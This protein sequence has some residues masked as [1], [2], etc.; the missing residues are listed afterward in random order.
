MYC[1][2]C[3]K[4]VPDAT[5]FCPYCGAEL[6]EFVI[7]APVEQASEGDAPTEP[8]TEPLVEPL[9]GGS[10]SDPVQQPSGGPQPYGWQQPSSGQQPF[11]AP[12][13]LSG[14]QPLSNQGPL[15][16]Q[17]PSYGAQQPYG[18]QQPYGAQ[19]PYGLQ[20][21]YGGQQPYGAQQPYGQAPLAVAPVAEPR[22]KGSKVP[23]IIVGIVV[24]LL[25]AG[26]VTAVATGVFT[27]LFNKKSAVVAL[28]DGTEN[29]LYGTS[30]GTMDINVGTSM[31]VKWQFG[32]DLAS[33]TIWGYS[34]GTGFVY[35]NDTLYYY[36][37]SGSGSG[38][39]VSITDE[40][41]GVIADLND[42]LMSAYGVDV[43]F[44]KIVKNGK[45]DRTYIES[46]NQE[47]SDASPS[48]SSGYNP[49]DGMDTSKITEI[50]NDFL[51]NEVNKQAVQDKFMSG[52][53][54]SSSGGTTTYQG[55]IDPI[56]F[57]GAL[58]D[59]ASER[60]KDSGYSS[61]ASTIMDLCDSTGY[62]SD[63]LN[64]ITVKISVKKNMLTGL[65]VTMGTSS[66]AISMS[67]DVT[68]INATDLSNDAT[69]QNILSAPVSSGSGSGGSGSSGSGS[70]LLD[71]LNGLTDA[72]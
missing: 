11:G 10:Q 52:V 26:G 40:S 58:R 24:I 35:T 44:N 43:D 28:Y 48:L 61:A 59:Y 12:Q 70:S 17:Q 2:N 3:G 19:P 32:K 8:P 37:S 51:S 57:F 25:I 54:S 68:D 9:S 46:I 42:S 21:P 64:D 66:G 63:Y 36:E 4:E 50:L 23:L 15:G 71:D 34:G 53:T 72:M 47:I 60:G 33:S 14:P 20:P 13:P 62:L 38:A 41:T 27:N 67:L 29:L 55:T 7:T 16:N 69:L 18:V 65:V 1:L 31:T 49:L 39:D 6:K 5:K 45:L 56:A 30:S 22:K